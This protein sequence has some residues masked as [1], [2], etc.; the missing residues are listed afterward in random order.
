MKIVKRPIK[1]TAYVLPRLFLTGVALFG[2]VAVIL[3]SLSPKLQ[4]LGVC[5]DLTRAPV[6][7][8]S[9]AVA[10]G[11]YPHRQEL[12][13]LKLQGVVAVIS[14][15][16]ETLPP[17]RM[18]QALE[19][20]NAAPFGLKLYKVPMSSL[21]LHDVSNQKQVS[22]VMQILRRNPDKRFYI[23]C[24]GGRRRVGLVRQAMINQ[25]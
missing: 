21:H 7:Q 8:L 24:Y 9:P 19:E 17:E 1:K 5:H 13:V 12:Q 3:C 23:H 10:L 16:D 18:L 4:L 20:K 15:L 25:R 22:A 11:P 6:Q 2:M 14:L